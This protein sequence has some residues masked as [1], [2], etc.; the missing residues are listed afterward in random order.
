MGEQRRLMLPGFQ[1]A[2][3]GRKK[4]AINVTRSGAIP[5]LALAATFTGCGGGQGSVGAA[6]SSEQYLHLRASFSGLCQHGA[7]DFVRKPEIAPLQER[8]AWPDALHET[9]FPGRKQYAGE[10]DDGKPMLVGT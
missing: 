8:E 2:G 9:R 4:T 7:D 1:G 3:R 5:V 6:I 10:A